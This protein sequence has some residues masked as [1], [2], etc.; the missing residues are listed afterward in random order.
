MEEMKSLLQLDIELSAREITI[1]IDAIRKGLKCYKLKIFLSP[2]CSDRSNCVYSIM[3]CLDNFSKTI[4]YSPSLPE[5]V[6]EKFGD[7]FEQ[8]IVTPL[9]KEKIREF[10]QSFENISRVEII[11]LTY[12]EPV[13][14]E[15]KML[16]QLELKDALNKIHLLAHQ[17]EEIT[18]QFKTHSFEKILNQ[19]HSNIIDWAEI[20]G[21]KVNFTAE[22]E[23]AEI[24]AALAIEIQECLIHLLKNAVDHGIESP[25]EREKLGKSQ[26]GSIKVTARREGG[27]IVVSVE[28]DGR[29]VDSAIIK[30][31]FEG[32]SSGKISG[33]SIVKN[34]L[35]A[36]SGE[37]KIDSKLGK[38]SKFK[39]EIP[40]NL[41]MLKVLLINLGGNEYAIPL[42]QISEIYK[43]SKNEV[44]GRDII[45]IQG[46][47]LPIRRSESKA[48]EDLQILLVVEKEKEKFA[49]IADD[50]T[51]MQNAFIRYHKSEKGI[52]GLASLRNGR[53]LPILY[54]YNLI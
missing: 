31:V 48:V 21:K 26:T 35:N 19:L 39:L 38:G 36:L 37:I 45:S 25:L 43:I 7:Y 29:G 53:T 34:K 42:S 17:L 27:K 33:L 28:D 5:I 18:S 4:K 41:I 20:G 46:Q 24:D 44:E 1:I 23:K 10:I 6:E 40:L 54:I 14:D 11:T 16:K 9:E 30:E 13:I 12:E 22:A 49:I 2:S 32:D 52:S 3:K 47:I 15:S 51:G 50:I 8:I